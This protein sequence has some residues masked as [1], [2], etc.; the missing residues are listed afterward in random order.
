MRRPDIVVFINGLPISVLE[1]KNP[2]DEEADIWK[3]FEQ[4]QTYQEEIPDLFSTN[5]V[6]IVSDGY[7]ARIGSVTAGKERYSYWRT[8]T[9]EEDRPNFETE[10]EVMV[11]GFF[12]KDFILDYLRYFVS[13]FFFARFKVE[14]LMWFLHERASNLSFDFSFNGSLMMS[15]RTDDSIRPQCSM[16]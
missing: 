14:L 11:K 7:N 9:D 15:S 10:L 5:V 4:I 12:R 6:N 1:L 13:F 8:L 3:A 16:T 2:L